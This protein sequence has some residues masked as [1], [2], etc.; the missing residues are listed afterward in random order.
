MG[1]DTFKLP[2]IRVF[3]SDADTLRERSNI[4]ANYMKQALA[5]L[6]PMLR[7]LHVFRVMSQVPELAAFYNANRLVDRIDSFGP[8]RLVVFGSRLT[9]VCDL[10]V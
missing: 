9:N 8:S 2:S 1:E 3:N 5:Q 4:H 10:F 7:I 6:S